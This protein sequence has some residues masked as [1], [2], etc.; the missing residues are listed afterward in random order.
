M[1]SEIFAFF[2]LFSIFALNEFSNNTSIIKIEQ[3]LL[4]HVSTGT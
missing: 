1:H 4:R 2:R 3:T